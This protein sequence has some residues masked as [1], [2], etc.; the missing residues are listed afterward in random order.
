MS[1]F[2]ENPLD[3]DAF[4][5]EYGLHPIQPT[6]DQREISQA[7]RRFISGYLRISRRMPEGLYDDVL[8]ANRRRLCRMILARI[9]SLEK[10][11]HELG[12]DKKCDIDDEGWI[13]LDGTFDGMIVDDGDRLNFRSQDELHL[14][15]DF[16]KNSEAFYNKKIKKSGVSRKPLRRI[17]IGRDYYD[18]Y[19]E[20]LKAIDIQP[21]RSYNGLK[22][23]A[24]QAEEAM[25]A[26]DSLLEGYLNGL[27][28]NEQRVNRSKARK[29][30]NHIARLE[31]IIRNYEQI[32]MERT[33]AL[34]KFVL[35]WKELQ[36][37]ESE[38]QLYQD[39]VTGLV[40]KADSEFTYERDLLPALWVD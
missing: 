31:Q 32:I 23:L 6:E 10:R 17:S 25:E 27:T 15:N 7:I 30:I 8:N 14:I 21:I 22:H 36:N 28:P 18:L 39:E 20:K 40:Q 11:F 19:Y 26:Y 2:S 13:A 5:I 29:L 37:R 1:D 38:L 4:N 9:V 34:H 33:N 16:M 12:M 35:E 3:L 24:E